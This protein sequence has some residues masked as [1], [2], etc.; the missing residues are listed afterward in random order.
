M[1]K[2]QY[3]FIRIHSNS[4]K[5]GGIGVYVINYKRTFEIESEDIEAIW[6]HSVY[7]NKSLCLWNNIQAT[8]IA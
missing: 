2:L 3:S 4:G 5:G 1:L 7:K 6:K 8:K